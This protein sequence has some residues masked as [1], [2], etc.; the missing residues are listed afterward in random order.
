MR[1]FEICAAIL[2]VGV[3]EHRVEPPI[4]I[5]VMSD[6]LLRSIARIELLQPAAKYRKNHCGFAHR[7]GL[8]ERS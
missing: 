8:P 1:T 2:P 3:E 4:E 7:V 6:I 5:V